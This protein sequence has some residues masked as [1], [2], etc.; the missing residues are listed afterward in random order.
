MCLLGDQFNAQPIVACDG[1][2]GLVLSSIVVDRNRLIYQPEEPIAG[3][4]LF[5]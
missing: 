5:D 2:A 3:Q 4:A 1:F